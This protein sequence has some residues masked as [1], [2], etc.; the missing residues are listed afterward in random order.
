GHL[1]V[2]PGGEPE[3][4]AVRLRAYGRPP[5]LRGRRHG[6]LPV[7]APSSRAPRSGALRAFRRRLLR[8]RRPQAR[9]GEPVSEL[10]D[11][12][13]GEA[14]R[15]VALEERFEGRLRAGEVLPSLSFLI[16][17]QHREVLVEGH[18]VTCSRHWL[19]SWGPSHGGSAARPGKPRP[20]RP[21]ELRRSRRW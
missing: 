4:D 16:A 6:V 5:G 7:G 10:L 8:R 2:P 13:L 18:S 15:P 3:P 14:G 1:R 11:R 17:E 12:G 9:E 21:R 19:T 20:A